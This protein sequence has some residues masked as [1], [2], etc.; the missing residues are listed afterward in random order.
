MDT[1]INCSFANDSN[2]T[3]QNEIFHTEISFLRRETAP[4]LDI[5]MYAKHEKYHSYAE[6]LL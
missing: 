5:D 2:K 3:D 6:R 1:C 4:D